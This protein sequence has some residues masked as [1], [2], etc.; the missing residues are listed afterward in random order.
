MLHIQHNGIEVFLRQVIDEQRVGCA[1]PGRDHTAILATLQAPGKAV[2][3][4]RHID[5]PH[6]IERKPYLFE[7]AFDNQIKA[8][9]TADNTQ[10]R[11]PGHSKVTIRRKRVK[12]ADPSVIATARRAASSRT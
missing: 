12:K 7:M 1:D 2:N 8:A 3:V 11:R 4:S 6:L 9:T 5:F 10:F